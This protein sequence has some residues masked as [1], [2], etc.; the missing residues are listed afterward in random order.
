MSRKNRCSRF[1]AYG[2]TYSNWAFDDGSVR[3]HIRKATNGS[4]YIS[5]RS[6]YASS[7]FDIPEEF[8]LN[9]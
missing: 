1:D 9:D 8:M 6:Q 4:G 2:L 5:F 3:G 7:A